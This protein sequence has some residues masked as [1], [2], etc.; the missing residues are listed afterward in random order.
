MDQTPYQPSQSGLE[1]PSAVQAPAA[2]RDQ[3]GTFEFDRVFELGFEGF[4]RNF[5]A[6]VGMYALLLLLVLVSYITCVGMIFAVP[7]FMAA[8]T[9]MGLYMVRG[10]LSSDHLFV[11]FKRYWTVLGTAILY[12]LGYIGIA[13]LF[14]GPLYYQYFLAFTG[15][16]WSSGGDA[17]GIGKMMQAMQGA[18]TQ[19]FTLLSYVGSAAAAWLGG[20]WI[21]A[22]PL[23]VERGYGAVEALKKSWEV[24]ASCQWWLLLVTF[25][26]SLTA[27]IGVIACLVGV[28]ASFPLA[29]AFQGAAIL[30][31][32]GEAPPKKGKPG[33]PPSADTGSGEPVANVQAGQP[34]HESA[35]TSLSSD[36]GKT[37]DGPAGGGFARAPEDNNPYGS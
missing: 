33:A 16:K 37:D 28:F 17:A 32:L 2:Q 35:P 14:S 34:G 25:V 31:L 18:Q 13:A 9:L 22:Y 7:H 36:S 15:V 19:L 8:A 10:E 5:G 3:F 4:Q 6:A 1:R 21:L 23:V 26:A 12:G 29:M 11:G 27:G 20:R 24:T 30:Q